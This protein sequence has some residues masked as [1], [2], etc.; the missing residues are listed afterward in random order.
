MEKD[1]TELTLSDK[2]NVFF[3]RNRKAI[4]VTLACI[5][6]V[7][8]VVLAVFAVLDYQRKSGIKKIETLV[9][10]FEK[11][12]VE[13]I[14]NAPD[15]MTEEE[16]KLLANEENKLI[17]NLSK[18]TDKND[19]VGFM[20][21]QEI[22]D[23]YFKNGDLEKALS[24]YEKLNLPE[25]QY[26]SGVLYFNAA[27]CSDDLGQ[28]EKAFEYYNKAAS[29]ESFPFKERALFNVARVQE[30]LDKAKAV[31]VYS[32]LVADYPNTEWA[33]LSKTRIIELEIN[34]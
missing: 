23:I 18:Y 15:S 16:K 33:N 24:Y 31:E 22:A 17:E 11:F 28:S 34:K 29:C 21:V 1:K 8:V 4:L 2:I 9:L 30:K 7:L 32:Q 19:Y 26:I 3:M 10:D 20:A 6:A 5:L 12:K 27:A 14:K 13:N 25:N